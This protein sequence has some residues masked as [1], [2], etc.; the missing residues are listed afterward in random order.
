MKVALTVWEN[1][2]SP[3]FDGA[4]MLLVA[5]IE[6]QKVDRMHYEPF[7][8]E[9][10]AS[11]V[12]MLFDLGIDVLICGAISNFYVNMVEAYGIRMIPFI[13]GEA[14]QI[15]DAFATGALRDLK[16]SRGQGFGVS[17]DMRETV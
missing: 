8:S 4:Q 14:D 3:M 12:T 1:R 13:T 16:G 15:I 7:L 17:S 6:D 2:I 11:K 10:S 5:N 9:N